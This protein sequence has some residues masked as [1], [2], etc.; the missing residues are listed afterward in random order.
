MDLDDIQVAPEV[1]D[2][3]EAI[4]SEQPRLEYFAQYRLHC[5]V[6]LDVWNTKEGHASVFVILVRKKTEETTSGHVS[7]TQTADV[8]DELKRFMHKLAQDLLYR[9]KECQVCKT[10]NFGCTCI[11]LVQSDLHRHLRRMRIPM[12]GQRLKRLR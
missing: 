12:F 9:E 1:A 5:A 8:L 2:V 10:K 11:R 7:L 4:R 6:Y 3:E